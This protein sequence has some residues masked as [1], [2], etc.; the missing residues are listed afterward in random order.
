LHPEAQ[1]MQHFSN[2]TH[3]NAANANKMD[4]ANIE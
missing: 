2:A 3:A 4:Y 1:I